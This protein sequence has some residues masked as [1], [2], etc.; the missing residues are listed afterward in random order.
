VEDKHRRLVRSHR[1][2]PFDRE[3][4]PDPNIRD[5]LSVRLPFH[6]FLVTWVSESV[7]IGN[8]E[9]RTHTPSNVRGERS[10]MEIPVLSHQG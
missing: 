9:L 5:Q 10:Y 6:S 1:S 2:G 8:P 4:K 7:G 3:L